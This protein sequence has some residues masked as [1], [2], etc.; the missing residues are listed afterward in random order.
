M[1]LIIEWTSLDIPDMQ[2]YVAYA[3]L[4]D[5]TGTFAFQVREVVPYYIKQYW[6]II[7]QNQE[8]LD[9]EYAINKTPAEGIDEEM[10]QKGSM[11]SYQER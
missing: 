5:V 1:H 3:F 11:E 4:H 8:L 7:G 6:L 2:C 9:K 10:S